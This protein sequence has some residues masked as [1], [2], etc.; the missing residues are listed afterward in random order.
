MHH[1]RAT[2][3]N[4]SIFSDA[5][6]GVKS[7]LAID[8]STKHPADQAQQHGFARA[9]PFRWLKRDIIMVTPQQAE[10]ERRKLVL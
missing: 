7:S 5:V 10:A 9:E 8:I 1:T 3:L 4:P 2:L 6:F